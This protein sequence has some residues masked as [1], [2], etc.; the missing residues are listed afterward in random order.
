V[1]GAHGEL[2]A[3]YIGPLTFGWS[4]GCTVPVAET[5]NRRG[6][7]AELNYGLGIVADPAGLLISFVDMTVLTIDGEIVPP[8][9]A[10]R[11]V[12]AFVLPSFVVDH[13]GTVVEIRGTEEMIADLI[14]L[15]PEMA[16][17]AGPEFV[18]AIEASVASKYWESWGGFWAG[19]GSIDEVRFETT[20]DIPSGNA[21]VETNVVIES[22][23]TNAA[24][25]V[26]LRVQQIAEGDDLLNAT[27][28]MMD[29]LG[30]ADTG[31]L[32]T[33]ARRVVTIDTTT[34]PHTLRPRTVSLTIDLEIGSGVESRRQ[35]ETHDW[36]FDWSAPECG[37]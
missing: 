25:D 9:V 7:T 13:E 33:T 16:P 15:M 34:D 10:D 19:F 26:V 37:G 32:F 23:G 35:V 20:A 11:A 27:A 5:V 29:E 17:M 12:A 14:A 4:A 18:A 6:R 22:L 1:I 8:G 21:T 2:G 24:G 3:A 28:T 31:A 36:T 30:A